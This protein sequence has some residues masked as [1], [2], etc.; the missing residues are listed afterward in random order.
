MVAEDKR[1]RA[2]IARIEERLAATG[3]SANAASEAA[4][5]ER[6]YIRNILNGKSRGPR[7]EN[8]V[9]LARALDCSLEWL[10]GGDGVAPQSASVPPADDLVLAGHKVPARSEMPRDLPV[11]GTAAGARS[12]TEGAVVMGGGPVEFLRRPSVLQGVTDAYVVYIVND[13][14]EPAFPHGEAACVHPHRPVKPGDNVVIQVRDES[15]DTYAYVKVLVRRT[16]AEVVCRQHNPAREITFPRASV[17]SIH[18]I[19][20][21]AELIGY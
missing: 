17:V 15:G 19:L 1:N 11:L 3:L 2:L 5:L 14:M 6:T 21:V 16:N 20:S 7:G 8:A 12:E 13:S 9:R 10:L 18:K 4:G